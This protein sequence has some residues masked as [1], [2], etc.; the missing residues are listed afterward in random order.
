ML[1]EY[2][3]SLPKPSEDQYNEHRT[4]KHFLASQT[5]TGTFPRISEYHLRLETLMKV[6]YNTKHT[7]TCL[8][9]KYLEKNLK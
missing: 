3:K 4:V 9:K 1:T 7:A 8:K 5:F 2:F 6:I